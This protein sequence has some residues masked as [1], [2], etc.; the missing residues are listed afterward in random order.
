[1]TDDRQRE[2]ITWVPVAGELAEDRSDFAFSMAK[3]EHG[4]EPCDYVIVCIPKGKTYDFIQEL[5][6]GVHDE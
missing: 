2:K 1:M 6:A 3:T 4:L 5:M